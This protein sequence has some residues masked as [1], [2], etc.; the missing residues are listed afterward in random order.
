MK[1]KFTLLLT[2][3]FTLFTLPVSGLTVSAAEKT[4]DDIEDG[5]YAIIAKAL[6]ADKDEA[7]GAATFMNED[8]TLRIQDGKVELTITIPDNEF[9]EIEGLQVEGVEPI[10]EGTDEGRNMTYPLSQLKSELNAQVQYAVPTIGLEHDVPFRFIL[11]GLDELPVIE[12]EIEEPETPEEPTDPENGSDDGED[13]SEENESDEGKEGSEEEE[14][15]SNEGNDSSLENGSYTVETSYLHADEDKPSAMARYMDSTVYLNVQDDKIEATITVNEHHTV[16]KLQ[17][18]GNNAIEAKLDGE[19]R[20]ETFVIEDLSSL[21]SGYAE[22][23]APLPDGSI[24]YGQ[25]DFRI[26]FDIDSISE[27]DKTDQPGNGIEEVLIQLDDGFYTIDTSYLKVGSDEKSSMGNYLNDSVFVSVENGNYL[28]TITINE[29]ETVTKLQVDGNDSVGKEVDGDKRYETF[30]VT[31]LSSLHSA[32]VEYQ[33]PFGDNI[34]EGQADFDISL[35]PHSV[36]EAQ[37]SDK[38]GYEEEDPDEVEEDPEEENDESTEGI[39]NEEDPSALVP[40]KVYT[41]DYD[42]YDEKKENLSVAN[43]FFT[44]EAILLEKDGKTYAQL[45]ITNGEMVKALSNEYGDAILVKVNNDGSIVVQLRVDNDLSDMLLDMHIVV[46]ENAMP[47]FPGYNAEH[48]AYLVFNTDTK[49]EVKDIEGYELA[50][51][52]GNENGPEVTEDESTGG[53]IGDDNGNNNDDNTP[54]KPEFGTNGSNG[55][56]NSGNGENG[57]NPQTGDTSKLMFYALLLIGS[58]VPLAI[59]FKRRF[60]VK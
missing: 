17:V 4:Y 46:P 14:E 27:V 6:H 23:Q 20:Y 48:E 56:G 32:Y 28:L 43:Q 58:L 42:I 31:D 52:A 8:A 9:A 37:Q 55:D 35:D 39:D 16:T 7:S 54:K 51:V 25:A 50:A 3:L 47:G 13:G 59:Q 10:V 11:E 57:I 41:I 33:A 49:E 44:G 15:E 26:D 12:D 19:N 38:P 53:V 30:E 40:D 24:H 34:F 5:E 60:A 36:K 18:D 45:T 29:D 1:R 2:I 22:Y 21:A